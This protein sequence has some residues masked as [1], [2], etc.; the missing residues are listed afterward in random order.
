MCAFRV[1]KYMYVLMVPCFSFVLTAILVLM[2]NVDR[3]RVFEVG[4]WP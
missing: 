4:L 3:F 2:S 1:L